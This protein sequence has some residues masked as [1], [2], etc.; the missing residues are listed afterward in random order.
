MPAATLTI[1]QVLLQ[2]VMLGIEEVL[3]IERD[4]SEYGQKQ[5]VQHR[6]KSS[7]LIKSAVHLSL[8]QEGLNLLSKT[9]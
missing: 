3:A 8:R 5:G 4:K 2:G 6:R 1:F 9:Q 7:F